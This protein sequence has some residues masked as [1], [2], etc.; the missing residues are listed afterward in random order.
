MACPGTPCTNL[1]LTMPFLPWGPMIFP[2]SALFA[3]LPRYF[4]S[5][6]LAYSDAESNAFEFNEA[7]SR[8]L[9][10]YSY[11]VISY[12]SVNFL[13][14]NTSPVKRHFKGMQA[15]KDALLL[16][17]EYLKNNLT[18][19]K[20]CN[21]I[22]IYKMTFHAL[23]LAFDYTPLF[24][25]STIAQCSMFGFCVIAVLSV[26]IAIVCADYLFFPIHLQTIISL[27]IWAWYPN[28]HLWEHYRRK[29][30]P[31]LKKE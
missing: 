14:Q 29:E 18:T 5:N 1:T 27:F 25:V 2:I 23:L 10:P 12:S 9:C 26:L 16:G 13:S 7:F 20:L 21:N 15:F 3:V 30:I 22:N 19:R 8:H 4:L 28:I 31:F 6:W 24:I 11:S 17:L